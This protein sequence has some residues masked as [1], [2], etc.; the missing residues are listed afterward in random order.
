MKLLCEMI[1]PAEIKNLPSR[2]L[3]LVLA[4][5]PTSQKF[6]KCKTHVYSRRRAENHILLIFFLFVV[7]FISFEV[8]V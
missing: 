8:A 1:K 6:I 5:N 2:T 3:F 4:S 7:F